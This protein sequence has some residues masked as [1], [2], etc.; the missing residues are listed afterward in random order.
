MRREV[1]SDL[2]RVGWIPERGDTPNCLG[3]GSN[4]VPER[5]VEVPGGG[6]P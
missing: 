3:G 4:G 2:F 5:R 1:D 6:S